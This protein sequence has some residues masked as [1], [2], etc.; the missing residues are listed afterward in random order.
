MSFIDVTDPVKPVEG[1]D[2]TFKFE[3]DF[4]LA[5]EGKAVESMKLDPDS[6]VELDDGDLLIEGW[7]ANFEGQDRQNENFTDG[8]FQRGIK[9]FLNGPAS[10]CYH[11]KHDINLGKVLSLEEV[12]GKGLKMRAR[13]DKQEPTSPIRHLYDGVRKGSLS[14]LSVGGFFRRKLTQDG[15]KINDMDFTEISVTPVPVHPSTTLSVLAGKA[16]ESAPTVEADAEEGKALTEEQAR[17]LEEAMVSLSSV[18]DKI[19]PKAPASAE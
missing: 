15:W 2:D 14:G 3:F 11:H 10:L 16:L 1:H 8:A 7:A 4:G 13:V 17:S 5:P 18:F 6:I 12:P 19:A 9:S